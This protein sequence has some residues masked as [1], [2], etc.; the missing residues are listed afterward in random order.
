MSQ[1]KL[2]HSGGNGVILA[3]PASNPS[4]DVTLKLPLAD[5]TSGQAIVTDASGNLSFATVADTNDFVKLQ[6]A[7]ATSA[8]SDL[9]FTSL[10]VTTYKFFRLVF[11]GLSAV[12]NGF[13]RFR[14]MVG[15]TAQTSSS[16]YSAV[17][18]VSGDN[19]NYSSMVSGDDYARLVG[20][21]GNA[22]NEGWRTIVEV[23]P[24]VSSDFNGA[25]NLVTAAG[26]RID[27]NGN[28]RIEVSSTFFKSTIDTDGFRLYASNGDIGSYNYTLY[29]VKR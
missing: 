24:Q 25:N 1:I 15:S 19:S 21:A 23:V 12:D 11:S 18:G 2:L 10:D 22:S 13:L 17:N 8:V 29:G 20:G 6:S 26:N 27:S 5:G 7:N 16:Y 14:F 4:S 3:A 9:S 28:Y